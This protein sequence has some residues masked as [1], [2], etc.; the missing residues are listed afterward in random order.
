M[1]I[2]QKTLNIFDADVGVIVIP[3][4]TDGAMGKGLA[5]Q[6]KW[7]HVEVFERYCRICKQKSLD[8]LQLLPMRLENGQVAIMFPTKKLWWDP[9]KIE[10]VESNIKKLAQ[11]CAEKNI[12]SLAIPP[13]GCGEGGLDFDVVRDLLFDAFDDHPTKVIFTV[14][15]G[16]YRR[17]HN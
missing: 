9:S 11:W 1:T 2:E 7:R 3:V 17:V 12:E 13:V 14:S 15:A 10:W 16:N 5:L 6:F 8:V 4:N